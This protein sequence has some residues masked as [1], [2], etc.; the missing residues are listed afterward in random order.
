MARVVL[1]GPQ[2]LLPTIGQAVFSLGIKGK[3]ATV[4]AG[5]EERE[6][7]D[8]ELERALEG[9]A[10]N[11]Q[12]WERAERVFEADPEL[13]Q[14]FRER[15]DRLRELQR[16]YRVRLRH[17]MDAVR[18][19]FQ[20]EGRRDTLDKAR[21][22]ALEAVRRLDQHHL[23]RVAETL[24][25]FAR[26]FRPLE[27][28]AVRYHR[29]VI[30]RRIAE[31]EAVCVAGGHVA[32]LMNRL[33]LFG[34]TDLLAGRAVFAWSAGAMV[35]GE[36]V[37]LFHDRPPQGQGDA[38]VLLPG[39][40][41]Y[42]GVLPLPHARRRLDLTARQNLSLMAWRFPDLRLAPMD[43]GDRLD[44]VDGGWSAAAGTRWLLPDGS[45]GS[46][47]RAAAGAGGQSG[48]P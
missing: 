32:V 40:A 10:R 29:A 11:L 24:G 3:L 22:D 37:V 38:E 16:I 43:E 7:E 45:V 31:T 15:Q 27:R 5:W 9:R 14:G 36:K 46:S 2:R 41:L 44:C 6:L 28:D 42:R 30:A 13:F 4:T 21:A 12:L 47:G 17:A 20:L 18:E 33:E 19:L 1:L 8:D 23:D 48:R 25:E 39:L 26:R 35:L 34:I